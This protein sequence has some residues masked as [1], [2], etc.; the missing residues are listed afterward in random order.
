MRRTTLLL[1]LG[2][3][4]LVGRPTLAQ[5]WFDGIFPEK[6]K[7]LGTVARGTKIRHAFKLVNTTSYDIHI[8]NYVTKCGC[9]DVKIGA[10]DIPP[11]TQTTIEAT[12]DTTKFQGFKASGLTLKLDRPSYAEVDLNLTCF[13]RG[14]ILLNPGT[15]DFQA[16][17]RGS[18]PVQTLT[19]NYLG[20]DPNWAITKVLTISP[21][22]SAT[23][24]EVGRTAGNVQYQISA[25]LASTAPSGHFKD[26]ITLVTND[27]NGQNIPIS[28]SANVQAAVTVSP[29]IINLGHVKPGETVTREI[30]VRSSQAFK[31]TGLAAQRPELSASE[32]NPAPL[33][34]HKVKVTLKAPATSGPYNASL[35]IATDLKDEPP[36]KLTAFATVGP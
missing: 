36:A 28:V 8:A 12:I 5:N 15:V 32:T 18:K 22:I 35:E 9:T 17:A 24:R 31:L 3:I 34:F 14:D 1:A 21:H 4:L 25:N 26:E 27:P 11:G 29:A 2:L 19:L 16:V 7:D 30:L 20:G 6:A 10:H 33:A 23:A 13:I